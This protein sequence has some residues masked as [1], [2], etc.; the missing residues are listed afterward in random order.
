MFSRWRQAPEFAQVQD[1]SARLANGIDTLEAELLDIYGSLLVEGEYDVFL[2]RI[3]PSLERGDRYGTNTARLNEDDVANEYVIPIGPAQLDESRVHL[4]EQKTRDGVV[5]TAVSLGLLDSRSRRADGTDDCDY[6]DEDNLI[7][8]L[9]DGHHKLL[10]AANLGAELD[11]VAI[12]PSSVEI[13][14]VTYAL[15]GQR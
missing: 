4:Y 14:K 8:F 12:V 9:L 3:S 1:L 2:L 11:V 13:R 6:V 15:H 10:A 5:P 7:H